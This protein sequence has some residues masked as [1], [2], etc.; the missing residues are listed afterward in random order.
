MVPNVGLGS[1]DK[2]LGARKGVVFVVWSPNLFI[3]ETS[4][5]LPL[6]LNDT[7]HCS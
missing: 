7:L 2:K 5:M 4:L 3:R 6:R 1:R